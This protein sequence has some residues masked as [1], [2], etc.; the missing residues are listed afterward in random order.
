MKLNDDFKLFSVGSFRSILCFSL[1]ERFLID[2][3]IEFFWRGCKAESQFLG[4]ELSHVK[5]I[6][7]ITWFPIK[8][9]LWF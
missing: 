4:D 3:N 5:I 1:M 7:N 6:I 2:D 8:Y 9:A